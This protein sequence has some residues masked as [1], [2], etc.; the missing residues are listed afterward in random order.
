MKLTNEETSSVGLELSDR[1]CNEHTHPSFTFLM[2]K[3]C[4]LI[5]AAL[6]HRL[7]PAC[8]VG[9]ETSQVRAQWMEVCFL[10]TGRGGI[11]LL[12]MDIENSLWHQKNS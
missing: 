3:R 11:G 2:T 12:R 1:E 9:A 4:V 8:A 7:V 6:E 5:N 10:R